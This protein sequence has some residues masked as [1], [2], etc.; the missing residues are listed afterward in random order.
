M[1]TGWR[2][3]KPWRETRDVV[4]YHSGSDDGKNK[5]YRPMGDYYTVDKRTWLPLRKEY[6]ADTATPP[7]LVSILSAEYD[8]PLPARLTVLD[9]PKDVPL[10]DTLAPPAPGAIPTEDVVQAHGLSL[11]TTPLAMDS[12][13]NV[14]IRFRCWLGG[15]RLGAQETPLAFWVDFGR[16]GSYTVGTRET[17]Y[18]SS[19]GRPYID[20]RT[21][22]WLAQPNGDQLK[23]YAPLEPNAK[24]APL[25]R[26][27]QLDVAVS[28]SVNAR[29]SQ[30][31][32][33]FRRPLRISVPLPAEPD[34]RGIERH[35]PP[36]SLSRAVPLAA[37]IDQ[38]RAREYYGEKQRHRAIE[39]MKSALGAVKPFTDAAQE[40]RL[41]LA[42][43]YNDVGDRRRA[44]QIYREVLAVRAQ[45]PET[46][47]RFA[48]EARDALRAPARQRRHWF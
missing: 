17:S 12:Q 28:P 31:T 23:V 33:F 27:L 3:M 10:V 2:Q 8:V 5:P 7:R 1:G 26:A 9:L 16:P 15:V 36:G 40:L 44:E 21:T 13:G 47:N 37:A 38:E 29:N 22:L 14:L 18:R 46:Q 20:L 43:L 41:E 35:L 6:L 19:D 24:G 34:P 32:A 11:Q 25:P 45:H 4:I 42:L 48:R 39:W 30:Y